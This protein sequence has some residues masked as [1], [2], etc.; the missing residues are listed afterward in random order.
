ML[1]LLLSLCCVSVEWEPARL[2]A[3]D[4]KGLSGGTEKSDSLLVDAAGVTARTEEVDCLL[5]LVSRGSGEWCRS[6]RCSNG[7]TGLDLPALRE[8]TITSTVDFVDDR[9][10]FLISTGSGSS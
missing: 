9:G 6:T 4:I 10:G 1:L 2:L 8:G 3:V 5:R 7:E